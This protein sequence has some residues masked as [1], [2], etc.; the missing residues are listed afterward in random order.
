M[1]TLT[2]VVGSCCWLTVS[3]SLF[4]PLVMRANPCVSIATACS[5]HMFLDVPVD[6][7][8]LAGGM[9]ADQ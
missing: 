2:S 6:E 3:D 5:L 7:G 9:V 4:F 1:D 8:A